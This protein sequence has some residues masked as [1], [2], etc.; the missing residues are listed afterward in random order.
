MSNLALIE[1]NVIP[2]AAQRRPGIQSFQCSMDSGIRRNDGVEKIEQSIKMK[3][4]GEL[5]VG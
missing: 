5:H 2:G 3:I 1:K 4:K